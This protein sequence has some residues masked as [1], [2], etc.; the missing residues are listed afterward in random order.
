[1]QKSGAP[2]SDG[3]VRPGQRSAVIADGRG[4]IVAE[5]IVAYRVAGVDFTNRI[6][7]MRPIAGHHV[8]KAIGGILAVTRA[9]PCTHGG[10]DQLAQSRGCATALVCQPFPMAREQ[11]DLLRL[12]PE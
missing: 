7:E 11:R 2:S 8:E 5:M 1:P 6:N 10:F 9:A 12:D 3:A 4:P